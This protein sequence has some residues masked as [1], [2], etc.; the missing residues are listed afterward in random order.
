[1]LIPLA[2]GSVSAA[3][4]AQNCRGAVPAKTGTGTYTL[5]LDQGVDA[6][7]G[8]VLVTALGAGDTLATVAHT[9]DTVKTVT[10]TTGG[11]AADCAFNFTVQQFAAGA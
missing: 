2:A 11:S 10:T 4:A 6:T 7:E 9:S 1:M 3:G 5:T 8:V